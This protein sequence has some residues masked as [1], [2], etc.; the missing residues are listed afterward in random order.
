FIQ[1]IESNFQLMTQ[2]AL[3]AE[4]NMEKLRKEIVILQGQLESS[5]MENK[6]LRAGQ[7][8]DLRAVE[9]NIDIALQYLHKVMMGANCSIRQLTSGVKSLH[10]VAKVLKSTGKISEVEAEKE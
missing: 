7:P 4:S 3:K 9:H 10:F 6:N 5:K 1:R 8:T 2:R